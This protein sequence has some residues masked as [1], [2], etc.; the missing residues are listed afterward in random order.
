MGLN[1]LGEGLGATSLGLLAAANNAEY[2]WNPSLGVGP[3][4]GLAWGVGDAVD[5]ALGATGF[6]VCCLGI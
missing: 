4:T 6:G 2:C 3:E 5:A 1:G